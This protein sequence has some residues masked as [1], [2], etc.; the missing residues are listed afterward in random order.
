MSLTAPETKRSMIAPPTM[1]SGKTANQSSGER[2]EVTMIE[3]E[4]NRS[5]ERM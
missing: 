3:Q 5:S 1:G 2:F 4:F